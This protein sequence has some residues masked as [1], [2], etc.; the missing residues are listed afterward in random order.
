[1]SK[2]PKDA[3]NKNDEPTIE[4]DYEIFLIIEVNDETI[5]IVE[6]VDAEEELK[7]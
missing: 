3:Q 5:I 2:K 6:V 4:P 7:N 1:M